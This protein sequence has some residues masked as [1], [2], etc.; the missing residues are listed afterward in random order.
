M[1]GK[2]PDPDNSSINELRNK[3]LAKIREKSGEI[4][5]IAEH[6]EALDAAVL[7]NAERSVDE[8]R[9]LIVA[10]GRL[11][12]LLADGSAVSQ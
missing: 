3:A 6:I 5:L 4:T 9:N 2:T 1:I 10:A 12:T 8:R 11:S 7:A